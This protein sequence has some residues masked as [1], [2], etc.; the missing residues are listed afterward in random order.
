MGDERVDTD[1]A[2]SPR[3]AQAW[4]IAELEREVRELRRTN[5]ALRR[6][7]TGTLSPDAA[8]ET[9]GHDLAAA[10]LPDGIGAG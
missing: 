10:G 7:V 5:R 4:R 8:A 6:W 1:T 9:D 2:M 3:T